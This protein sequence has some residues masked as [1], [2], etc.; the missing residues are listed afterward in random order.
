MAAVADPGNR[1]P[2]FKLGDEDDK[3]DFQNPNGSDGEEEEI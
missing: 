2:H 1:D 3:D